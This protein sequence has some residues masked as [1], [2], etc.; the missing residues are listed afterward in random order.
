MLN[1]EQSSWN[2][3]MKGYTNKGSFKKG[4]T[5]TQLEN[6]PIWK[7]GRR[8][9]ERGY[10]RIS[11]APNKWKYEH[12][13]V[14]ENHLGR[15]LKKGETVHH[16]NENKEDNR[17]ENLLLFSTVGGHTKHHCLLKASKKL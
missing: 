7:G 2:K 4:H 11:I 13:L 9:D 14:M 17:I 12:T 15:R 5:R 3:G 8:K 1:K 10:I 6:N 16:I